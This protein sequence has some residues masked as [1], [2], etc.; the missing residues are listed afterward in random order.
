MP[1]KPIQLFKD[2]AGVILLAV[3][4]ALF[5]TNWTNP[6]D[7]VTP[8]DPVLSLSL[9]T[10]FW[11]AGGVAM[12]VALICLFANRMEWPLCLLAW[13]GLNGLVYIG[14]THLQGYQGVAGFLE[15]LSYA[16]RL[17]PDL[18]DVLV[19]LLAGYLLAGGI[20]SLLWLRKLEKAD[21][22]LLKMP[23]PACGIHIKFASEN[24]GQT[25]RCPQCQ[26]SITLRS[27]ESLKMACFFC[28]KHIEFPAHAIGNKIACPHCKMEITLKEPA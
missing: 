8:L 16:F 21:G 4:T 10:V 19:S 13:L 18:G 27:A 14:G 23:C 7:L 1:P 20:V 6:A 25:T 22:K 15:G 17:P 3:G 26:T 11:V 24:L 28:H 9:R 12:I 5:L 2:S